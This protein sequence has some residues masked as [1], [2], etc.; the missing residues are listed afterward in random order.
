MKL[1][2]AIVIRQ[3]V[4]ASVLLSI[5]I[6]PSTLSAEEQEDP[7]ATLEDRVEDLRVKASYAAATD[8]ARELLCLVQGEKRSKPYEIADV[9]R[10]IKTLEF[11]AELPES[12][13]IKLAEADKLE[14]EMERAYFS[15]DFVPGIEMAKRQLAIRK[16]ILGEEHTDVATTLDNLGSMRKRRGDYARAESL[17]RKALALNRKLLGEEHPS[18]ATNLNNIA[19]LLRRRGDYAGAESLHRESLAM[20]RSLLGEEHLEVATSLDNLANLLKI[21]GDYAGAEP[22]SRRALA[23]R[24]K[25][26]GEDHRS[27][28]KSLN[29][30]ADLLLAG[31]DYAR[32]EPLF[33][34]SLAMRR[35]LLG[36]E[37]TD[38]AIGLN[39]LA[40]VLRARGDYAG[41]EPLYRESLAL[42]RNL[43]GEKHP[44]VAT[45]L[46][47]LAGLLKAR[48]DYAGAEP[49]F[50]QVLV[51]RRTHLGEEHPYVAMSLNDL[52]YLLRARGDYAGAEPLFREALALSRKV[53]GKEHP[54]IA[55]ILNN[56]ATL[57]LVRGDYAE[58]EPLYREALAMHRKLRGQEHP[59]VATS[60]N[61]LATLLRAS[62]D[63][64]GAEPL[65][66]EALAM[67]RKLL[68]EG[69][70]AVAASLNGLGVLL[71]ARGD[72]T[73]AE[74]LIQE[75]LAMRRKNLREEHPEIAM[76]LRSLADVVRA[77]GDYVRAELLLKQ[78]TDVFEL[79]R[80]RAGAG[81]AKATFTRSPYPTL[82]ATQLE[83]GKE[84]KAWL[85]CEQSLSQV[86]LEILQSTEMRLLTPAE[87]SQED[88]LRMALGDAER[89]YGVC[90][91]E[92]FSDT[93][94]S[95]SHRMEDTRNLLLGLEADWSAFQ[96]EIARKYPITSGRAYSL[97]RIQSTLSD[98]EAILGWLD[99]KEGKEEN[100]RWITSAYVIPK[101]GPVRWSSLSRRE[102]SPFE[103]VRKIRNGIFSSWAD[104]SDSSTGTLLE[105]WTERIQPVA[106]HLEDI[107]KLIVLPSGA[108]LGIPVE[109]LIDRNGD[110]MGDRFT[111]SYAP[112]ATIHAWLAEQKRAAPPKLQPA[113][114][115]GDP[116]F[117]PDHL[118]PAEKPLLVASAGKPE[119]V[120]P[121][122]VGVEIYRNAIL[123]NREALGKLP[124]L[125]GTRGEIRAL[126][127]VLP[128]SRMLLGE[129]AT[130]QQLAAMATSGELGSFRILHFATHG[131][132]DDEQPGR[133]ALI[134][135]QVGL[136]DPLDA[137]M[138]GGR[139]YDG[140]ITAKEILSGWELAADLVTLSACETGL[141]KE[142]QGEGYVGLAHAFMQVGARSLLV[143]LWEVHDVATALLMKRFYENWIGTDHRERMNKAEALAEAKRWLRALSAR[144]VEAE[145]KSLGMDSVE[146]D[147]RSRGLS[148]FDSSD[149]AED[150]P[151][152]RPVFWAPFILIGDRN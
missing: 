147:R 65:L 115:V 72:Y 69:H 19:V 6:S 124:R 67:R 71:L 127:T 73:E 109:A 111:V 10:L 54:D 35:K 52:A 26:L 119:T 45:N 86:L 88:S 28:A 83:L 41:A 141:G 47:N 139:I 66:R 134:F 110:L 145:R 12:A 51:M 74:L 7:I 23:M 146:E 113:L 58:A 98:S 138:S 20:R 104:V 18:V 102:G 136:P 89:L 96:Q 140:V 100:G 13:R 50:R 112:S 15:A 95:A 57:L 120:S 2:K 143:G 117:H 49:L 106:K 63:L 37:H 4:S 61:R 150:R 84:M 130:E 38:V 75:S 90:R 128:G 151:F 125:A 22:L 123:G 68:R 34:E 62:G 21:R 81:L 137:A 91:T 29:N 93:T 40:T 94:E 9:E 132:T 31:G 87:S 131:I 121:T 126:D 82:A 8:V 105:L 114:L 60:L 33:R 122:Y 148:L 53:L 149:E 3:L 103:R 16:Q 85:S 25:L 59:T 43:L 118:I 92:A 108:M 129:G 144:E 36:E 30:L 32:A 77:R 42:N 142:V 14:S 39:N 11:A 27:V 99:V 78:A 17:F 76:S 133:S 55:V 46:K 97:A 48:G 1:C 101:K 56:L 5:L 107:E 44:S 70:P 80:L 64:A 79:A 152:E 24:R 116:P 135:S